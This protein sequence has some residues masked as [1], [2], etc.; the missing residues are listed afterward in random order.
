MCSSQS[1]WPRSSLIFTLRTAL[2]NST[3]LK[4]S[5]NRWTPSKKSA[6]AVG[7]CSS[8]LGWLSCRCCSSVNLILWAKIATWFQVSS[9]C[10]SG[11]SRSMQTSSST[12]LR[13]TQLR[14][15]TTQSTRPTTRAWATEILQACKR[16]TSTHIKRSRSSTPQTRTQCGQWPSRNLSI[17]EL[18]CKRRWTYPQTTPVCGPSSSQTWW[19]TDPKLQLRLQ[20]SNSTWIQI[21]KVSQTRFYWWLIVQ[22]LLELRR[23]CLTFISS[24]FWQQRQSRKWSMTKTTTTH[25]LLS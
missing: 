15:T 1:S 19:E 13:R 3:R 17:C 24:I 16:R 11:R 6:L 10:Q 8:S 25:H 20:R 4:S 18:H 22:H 14:L 21:L 7:F 12:C 9:R 23:H 2:I 5:A